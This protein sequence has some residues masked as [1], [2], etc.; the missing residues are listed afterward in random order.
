VTINLLALLKITNK[1]SEWQCPQCNFTIFGKKSECS[2]CHTKRGGGNKAMNDWM[3]PTCKFLVFGSKQSCS[4]C[5]S[6]RPTVTEGTDCQVCYTPSSHKLGLNCGHVMCEQCVHV[7]KKC[8]F[9]RQT[10]TITHRL[11]L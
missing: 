9:C 5:K 10:I 1:M 6:T 4:K 3:C 7:I 11:Y 8:P 2:K